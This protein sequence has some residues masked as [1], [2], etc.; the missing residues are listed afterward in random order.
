MSL[1]AGGLAWKLAMQ[2]S[3][4][5]LV[6]GV[7]SRLGG[8][9]PIVALTEGANLVISL[10]KTGV[11][12]SLDNFFATYEVLPGARLISNQISTMPF[13]NQTVAANAIIAQALP[14]SFRMICPAGPNS[15]GS[16]LRLLTMMALKN[17]LKQHCL[18]GGTFTLIMPSGIVDNS[19]LLD[20]RDIGGAGTQKQDIWQLDFLQP[21]VTLQQAQQAQNGLTQA[22]TNGVPSSSTLST[23]LSG[24][25]S[26]SAL[27]VGNPL[28]LLT[29]SFASPPAAIPATAQ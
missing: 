13:A 18:S 5:L 17:T 4:I 27:A 16:A 6:G 2:I 8:I 20:M 29:S 26:G 23:S 15:G 11:S 25:A 3:P 21:L 24:L 7:A 19:L 22:L 9:V 1:S 12:S 10:A 28:S 14:V